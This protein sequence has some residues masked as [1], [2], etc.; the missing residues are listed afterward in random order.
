MPR[1]PSNAPYHRPHGTAR[2]VFPPSGRMARPPMARP[3]PC[4]ARIVS[5]GSGYSRHIGNSHWNAE[6][7]HQGSP[8]RTDEAPKSAPQPT[9]E[10]EGV[11]RSGITSLMM[12]N[13][14]ATQQRTA[15]ATQMA[16]HTVPMGHHKAHHNHQPKLAERTG[17][18]V[19][20][21]HGMATHQPW[22]TIPYRWT[23]QKRTTR[24]GP[25]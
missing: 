17:S 9:A 12:M 8:Y 22:L 2:R 7:S 10:A 18:E 11:W 21:R 20:S 25:E 19:T 6:A 14:R 15:K 5:L 23:S 4:E 16:H 24:K 1:I 13:Q 3:Y